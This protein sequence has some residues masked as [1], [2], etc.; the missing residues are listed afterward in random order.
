MNKLLQGKSS[1]RI[2]IGLILLAGFLIAAFS[3]WIVEWLWLGSLGYEQVFWTIK[4]TQFLLLGGALLIALAYILPNMHFLAKQSKYINFSQSPLG[5]LNL[6]QLTHKQFKTIFYSFGT[7]FSLFFAFAY[8]MRWDSYFRFHWNETFDKVDP[9]FGLDIGFYLFRL[10]FIETIQNSLSILVFFV[11]L[12]MLVFYL[13]SGS[14]SIQGSSGMFAKDSVKKHLSINLGIWLMLLAWGYYLERYQLLYNPNGAVFGA[15]YTDINIVLPVLWVMVVFCL[16]LAVLAFAQYFMSNFR[17]LIIG[18]VAT[19]LVGIVGQG[20]LP[21]AIQKF[22]VE[23]NELQLETPYLKHNIEQTREAFKLNEINEREYN[24]RDTLTWEKLENNTSTL[25]NIR[26]WDPRL[27]I[28]T[29]RQ[30]QE[31]RLYYQFYNVTLDRYQT[32]D[33]YMQMMVS[34]RE[35]SEEMPEQ[36]DTWVNRHLQ[37][38]HGYG[39]VMSPVAQIGSQGDPIFTIKDLPPVTDLGLTVG[40]A[41][42][43]YGDHDPS[44]KI[45]DTE[46]EELDYPR[47]DQ[48]V[49]NHYDGNGGVSIDSFFEKLLFAWEFGDINILLTD[50][51][52][53][54]S[55]IQFWR[56]VRERVRRTAPFLQF[57]D[58]PYMVLVNGDLKWIQ[59]AYTTSPHYPYSERY[60]GQLNYIRNSVKVVIDAYDGTLD[61]YAIE[62]DD[63]ILNVYRDIFPNMFKTL[64]EM[65]ESIKAHIKYPQTLFEVQMDIYNT[66]HMTNPQVFYNNED[67]WERPNE[68]YGG[69]QIK[70][71][72]YYVLSKLPG[73]DQL[74]YMLIS[75]LTPNNRDNMIAWMTAKSD[76]PQYGEVEVFKLPK[77]R[78]I[79]GPAQIEARIDQDTEISRQLALWDQR[80]SRV[81]R[82]NLM[83]IPIEDSFIY[84]EPVFLIAEGVDIPQLQRV[85]VTVGEQVVMEPTLGLALESLFGKRPEERIMAATEGVTRPDTLQAPVDRPVQTTASPQLE[86]FKTLWSEAQQALRDGN[87]QL[88]G[89]KMKEIEDL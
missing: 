20:L 69:Q 89:E 61:F 79:L 41:G 22:Q 32:E 7:L 58:E 19:A 39:L 28:Q 42:I 17:W 37:F 63:P 47:G 25:Q 45:V 16:L 29:Y 54:G 44:Y 1:I 4:G 65:P 88:F 13:Y 43:Y 70:M 5:Q 55:K 81:I 49:Y 52:R 59:D 71:E 46:I 33:G 72:P 2:W 31:I 12:V 48:N 50:Y 60:N 10:P 67:L 87:W 9:I 8:Y 6:E 21:T 74:Q 75:P 56:S 83:I 15:G 34:A 51:I 27:V 66:Y 35:L 11:T 82:G 14:L 86:E 77:E 23:P 80:G 64:D 73:E 36:A 18:G 38:T 24:A 26:L 62:D 40:Q 57:Q 85:I 53:D 76:F 30:L 68:K 84:V 78:L 3:D